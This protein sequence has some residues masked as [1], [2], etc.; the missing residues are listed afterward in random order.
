MAAYIEIE[1]EKQFN[2]ILDKND[3]VIV[4]FYASWCGPCKTLAEE[5]AGI[6]QKHPNVT[7]VKVNIDEEDNE[8]IVEHHNVTSLPHVFYYHKKAQ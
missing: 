1:N 6:K 2:D 8:S 4:D 3:H 7:I 5:F